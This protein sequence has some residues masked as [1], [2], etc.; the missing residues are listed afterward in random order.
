MAF[1]DKVLTISE[2]TK[3]MADSPYVGFDTI[4][5]CEVFETPG[6]LKIANRT[7]SK[8]SSTLVGLPIAYVED[9]YG[10]YYFLTSDGKLYKNDSVLQTGLTNPWDLTIYN[11]Y[12]I[13]SYGTVISVYGALSASPTWFG[14][15]KTGLNGSYYAKLL[16]TKDGDLFIGNGPYM[17]KIS[18][19]VAGAVGVAP[20]ATFSTNVMQLPA[21]NAITTMVEVG[22]YMI[23]GTQALNGSWFNGTNGNI[24]NLYLWDRVNTKPT[25]LT[26][27]LNE[28]SIM[29]MTS[30]ANRVYVMAGIRGNL[31]VTDTTSFTKIKRI[32][33]NQNRVFGATMRVYPNAMS[34]N[35]QGNLLVGTS[36][37]SDSFGGDAS[38]VRQGVYEIAL[39]E[40][41][42][43]I[44][45]QQVSTGN[46]GKSQVLKIGFVFAGNGITQMGWQDASTYGLDTV[47]FRAY[48]NH[49][50]QIETQYYLIAS[51]NQR[52][53]FQ[54]LEFLLGKPLTTGQ[55]I[56]IYYRKNLTDSYTL[57]KTYSFSTMGAVISTDDSAALADVQAVQLK[58]TLS[59]P[60]SAAAS[61]N[62]ELLSITIW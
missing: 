58:I 60:T 24:A 28:S 51:R 22:A 19:F 50:A 40:G 5:N 2:W 39:S 11:D 26:G 9:A 4:A 45:K 6:A 47:D 36:T 25:M 35:I 54:H 33:W 14:N 29:A 37:L 42:P 55:E 1:K 17:A 59:Q 62:I 20:T 27:S 16:P 49:A 23:I 48:T 31:Y 53:T 43:T 10:N 41:Y 12:L 38:P 46:V 57:L 18:S 15:W 21:D 44:F 3:G 30:Y 34:M 32:P 61:A 13:V 52:K 8:I 56:K 7:L